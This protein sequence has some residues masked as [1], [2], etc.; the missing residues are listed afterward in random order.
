MFPRRLLIATL[1]ATFLL[2]I[3]LLFPAQ[4]ALQWF[5]P[6]D[7]R[8][9]G[10][11]GTIWR[12]RAAQASAGGIYL[13]PLT[14]RLRPASLLTARLGY[15][16]E[17]DLPGGYVNGA[18]AMTITGSISL[19]DLEAS[20]PLASV[21]RLMPIA[22]AEGRLSADIDHSIIRAGWPTELVGIVSIEDL[23]YRPAGTNSIGNYRVQFLET[24]DNSLLGELS[25]GGGP[26]EVSGELAV[27]ADRAYELRGHVMA[28]PGAPAALANSLRFLG[29]EDARGRREFS[30]AG[31]L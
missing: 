27:T 13:S 20:V 16:I 30:L 15:D 8:L 11:E 29:S 14:W 18:V 31:R 21:S 3:L 26:L 22:Q 9:V 12:G 6:P 24:E 19:S 17:A 1:V 2:G 23:V 25:D 28:R 4:L 7:L 10:I 5:S